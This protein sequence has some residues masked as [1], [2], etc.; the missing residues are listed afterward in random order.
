MLRELVFK[1]FDEDVDVLNEWVK[2]VMED[3]SQ[4][5]PGDIMK[6]YDGKFVKYQIW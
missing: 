4:L 5:K 6:V 3:D 2:D 1:I